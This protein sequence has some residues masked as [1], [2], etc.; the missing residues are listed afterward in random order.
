[1]IPLVVCSLALVA[2]AL[3]FS[4]SHSPMI[5]K[6]ASFLLALLPITLFVPKLELALLPATSEG[7]HGAA[8]SAPGL[9]T[10]LLVVYVLVAGLLIFREI[11]SHIRLSRLIRTGSTAR[12]DL[13]AAVARFARANALSPADEVRVSSDLQ[14]PCVTGL[15]RTRLLLPD[16]FERW[17][18]ATKSCVLIHELAHLTRRDLLTLF[19]GRLSLAL[20][21]FNPLTRLLQKKLELECELACD[22]R[23]L[24]SGVSPSAYGSVL[25]DLASSR[26]RQAA[27]PFSRRSALEQRVRSMV[28]PVSK[29]KGFLIIPAGL[30]ML[31]VVA[32]SFVSLS[33][34][35]Q[36]PNALAPGPAEVELRLT[37]D[38]FPAD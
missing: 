13:A 3:L 11:L 36:S 7:S 1:M 15:F 16:D 35:S 6:L 14:A 17:N 21:W 37:A 5:S 22:A 32:T 30:L 19:V 29:P 12:P 28:T 25:C 18:K 38:P 8:S 2:L 33:S 24:A 26:F 4:R 9:S 20:N 27:L 10:I 31:T 34:P 23:V